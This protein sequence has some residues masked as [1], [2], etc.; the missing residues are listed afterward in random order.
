MKTSMLG[1]ACILLLLGCNSSDEETISENFNDTRTLVEQS[2]ADL[3][4]VIATEL[5]EQAQH[6]WQSTDLQSYAVTRLFT[7][8]NCDDNTASDPYSP[9]LD[10]V[11]DSGDPYTI[12]PSSQGRPIGLP[13]EEFGYEQLHERLL[14]VL[15]SKPVLLGRQSGNMEELPTFDERGVVTEW[16]H[17][18]LNQFFYSSNSVGDGF[19]YSCYNV[20]NHQLIS[21]DEMG[22]PLED[23][24]A[25]FNVG[26][27][28]WK[29]ADLQDYTYRASF[30]SGSCAEPQMSSRATVRV[31]EG[32]VDE[33]DIEWDGD[34]RRD[35]GGA[36]MEELVFYELSYA[37]A[38]LPDRL[39]ATMSAD[40]HVVF[41]SNFGFPLSFYVEYDSESSDSCNA[42][43]I[44]IES[45]E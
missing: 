42:S 30:I 33:S 20:S 13:S 9:V 43:G 5:V 2:I 8:L 24:V 25:E 19:Y 11:P 14:D 7:F 28:S 44:I 6:D 17:K 15:A 45:F 34:D 22:Y 41:D 12:Y 32:T 16:F 37:I 18:E 10:V 35:L 40:D 29:Q 3:K 36:T 27:E 4:L 21:L 38:N 31:T 39:T 1:I 23:Y 26:I